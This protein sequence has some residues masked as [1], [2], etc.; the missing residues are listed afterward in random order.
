MKI[1]IKDLGYHTCLTIWAGDDATPDAA[2][3]IYL[4]PKQRQTLIEALQKPT[5]TKQ[6]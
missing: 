5:S 4:T 1:E 2:T 6:P 3:I